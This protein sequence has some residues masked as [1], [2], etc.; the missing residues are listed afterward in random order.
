M[1]RLPE[2]KKLDVKETFE[3]QRESVNR[4][5]IPIIQKS[6]NKKSF[7]VGDGVIRHIIHERHRHQREEYLNKT[8][9]DVYWNDSEKRRK[10]ANSRRSDVGKNRVVYFMFLLINNSIT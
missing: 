10:H 7:P 9:K 5:I 4:Y 8:N 3:N 6:I 1:D 2:D